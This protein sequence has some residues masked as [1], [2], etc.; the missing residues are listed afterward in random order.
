MP[1]IDDISDATIL[2]QQMAMLDQALALLAQ[3][4]TT[5]ASLFLMPAGALMPPP[6]MRSA[7]GAPGMNADPPLPPPTPPIPL[8]L[9]LNPPISDPATLA[10]LSAALTAQR[11]AIEQQLLDMGYTPSTRRG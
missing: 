2:N 10:D 5:I 4:G 11:D 1:S 9:T 7:A 3:D 6:P 8:A